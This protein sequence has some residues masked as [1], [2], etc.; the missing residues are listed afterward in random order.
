MI[1]WSETKSP[2]ASS[3]VVRLRVSSIVPVG[4]G[5]VGVVGVSSFEQAAIIQATHVTA[6]P[7]L[8]LLRNSFLSMVQICLFWV[9]F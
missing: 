1:P 2:T 6:R 7:P 5:V 9:L 3:W 4:V 8:I